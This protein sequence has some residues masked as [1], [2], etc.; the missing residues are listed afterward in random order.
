LRPPFG[1]LWYDG[2]NAASNAIGYAKFPSRSHD[3]LIRDYD[4]AGNV[5]K[6][7]EH[8]G[9]EMIGCVAVNPSDVA[10]LLDYSV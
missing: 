3:T 8:A 10:R 1:R 2:P 4:E 5:I 7:H 6:T 9:T